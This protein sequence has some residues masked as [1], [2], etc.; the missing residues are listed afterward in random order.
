MTTDNSYRRQ[1]ELLPNP[2]VDATDPNTVF[3]GPMVRFIQDVLTTGSNYNQDLDI[4]DSNWSLE[5]TI[6]EISQSGALGANTP[7][8]D[9]RSLNSKINSVTSNQQERDAL[10][11]YFSKVSLSKND[12]NA[13]NRIV[14]RMVD[15]DVA[16]PTAPP[17]VSLALSIDVPLL[18]SLPSLAT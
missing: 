4:S 9:N 2:L 15:P 8:F 18:E 5:E 14:G 3:T 13:L 12:S 17:I 10:V 1:N 16:T 11:D 6:N 7:L